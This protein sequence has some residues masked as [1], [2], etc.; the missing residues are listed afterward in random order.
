M[1]GPRQVAS[2]GAMADK[3]PIAR[4]RLLLYALAGVTTAG[5][6]AT[7]GTLVWKDRRSKKAAEDADRDAPVIVDHPG[8]IDPNARL[9]QRRRL[10]KTNLQVS[11]VGIGA[12]ALE[13]T[14]P[15]AR[16]V[17]L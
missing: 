2:E 11:I 1:P 6:A 13:G 4:R 16:A 14:E 9:T 17:D 10:G 7:A 12:G 3:L 5:V 8:L 15:I